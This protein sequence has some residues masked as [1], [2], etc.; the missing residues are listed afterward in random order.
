ME[1]GM[2][3]IKAIVFGMILTGVLGFVFWRFASKSTE[4]A[5]SRLDRETEAVRQKQIELTDKIKQANEE[6]MK[7]RAEA[8]ALVA[9]MKED[10]S[11]TAQKEREKIV[12]KARQDAEE[13][14]NK[15][16]RTK[17]DM[18]KVIEQEMHLKAIDFTVLMMNEIFSDRI[19]K[20][21]NRDL[22]EE[23]LDG[24]QKVDMSIVDDAITETEI[25]TVET[26][27][28]DIQKR[29]EEIIVSRLGRPLQLKLN[30]DRSVLAGIVIRFGNLRLDGSL[31]NLLKEKGIE[32]KERLERG[33]LEDE[34]GKKDNKPA[35]PEDASAG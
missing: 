6:L 32:M 12:N 26:I 5:L 27:E 3:M 16:Q 15:A 13:I 33:L 9:K 17:E 14:I 22:I 25:T 30:A 2:L 29:L 4:T 8:D 24:L 10:A 20:A 7:R 18:R 1:L 23:Y 21:V 19:K 28:P 31:Y 11:E 34:G 35:G